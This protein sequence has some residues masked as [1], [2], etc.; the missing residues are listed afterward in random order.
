MIRECF[1][2]FGKSKECLE[3]AFADLCS[4]FWVVYDRK[5]CP[6]YGVGFDSSNEICKLCA[7]YF[8]GKE[9]KKLSTERAKEN[10]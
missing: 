3:C 6:L 2:E 1:G 5:I 4:C 10:Q 8:A 9:C 7:E